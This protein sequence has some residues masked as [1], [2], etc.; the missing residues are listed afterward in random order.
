[1]NPADY[2]HHLKT[3]SE[4][5]A[6]V[7]SAERAAGAAAWLGDISFI[8]NNWSLL[9]LVTYFMDH[10]EI[11]LGSIRINSQDYEQ[12]DYHNPGLEDELAGKTQGQEN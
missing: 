1:M 2:E 7:A 5:L 11:N 4:M 9:K 6:Y 12:W 10:K 3:T 8:Q